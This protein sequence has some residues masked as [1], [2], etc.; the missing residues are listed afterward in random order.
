MAKDPRL[1]PLAEA[2]TTTDRSAAITASRSSK[3][4]QSIRSRAEF[5][6]RPVFLATSSSTSKVLETNNG[7]S[8]MSESNA[9]VREG[10]MATSRLG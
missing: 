10:D 1:A 5:S 4:S 8:A 2:G 3:L 6:H 9:G 7:Q